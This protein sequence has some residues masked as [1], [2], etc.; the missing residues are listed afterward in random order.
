[1][2]IVEVLYPNGTFHPVTFL[3]MHNGS[4]KLGSEYEHLNDVGK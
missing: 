4:I 1:M 3:G 2:A